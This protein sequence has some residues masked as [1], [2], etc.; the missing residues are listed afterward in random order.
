MKEIKFRAWNRH[1]SLMLNWNS[2]CMSKYLMFETSYDWMQFTGL[3]DKNGVDIYE[4]DI[5]SAGQD[6]CQ[7]RWNQKFA[8]F[9][10]VKEGWMHDHFFGEAVEPKDCEIIGNIYES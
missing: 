7:I 8:S 10:L 2:L 9:C 3:K 5:V 6:K 4:G 1:Q